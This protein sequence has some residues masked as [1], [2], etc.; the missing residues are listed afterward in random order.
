MRTPDLLGPSS[1]PWSVEPWCLRALVPE[2]GPLTSRWTAP[3]TGCPHGVVWAQT[4]ILSPVPHP[5]APHLLPVEAE[6][7][8]RWRS[9]CGQ[10]R[11]PPLPPLTSVALICAPFCPH[12]VCPPP[13]CLAGRSGPILLHASWTSVSMWGSAA[14]DLPSGVCWVFWSLCHTDLGLSLGAD[15]CPSPPCSQT[16]WTLTCAVPPPHRGPAHLNPHAPGARVPDLSCCV[17]GASSSPSSATSCPLEMK[18]CA[19]LSWVCLIPR[20]T[21]TE[22]GPDSGSLWEV[23]PQGQ[24]HSQEGQGRA[25]SAQ[26]VLKCSYLASTG[27]GAGEGPRLGS[28]PRVSG[29]GA[30]GPLGTREPHGACLYPLPRMAV[31]QLAGTSPLCPHLGVCTFAVPV[32]PG[33]VTKG[34]DT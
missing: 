26:K 21:P 4:S 2:P 5:P 28:F 16:C 31:W 10:M 20:V 8:A 17:L 9:R 32:A 30:S 18:S 6:E 27:E 13:L 1:A 19:L 12:P 29:L 24:G 23:W 25:T 7:I 15:P 3:L 33:V 34:T 11:P 22:Q 14:W